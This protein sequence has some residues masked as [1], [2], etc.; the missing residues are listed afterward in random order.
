MDDDL[1]VL[2]KIEHQLGKSDENIQIDS[3]DE[4]QNL[5]LELVS[6]ASKTVDIFTRDLAVR[7]YD[8]A[9]FITALRDLVVR[10]D[11]T[12]IRI[13]IIDPDKPIKHG[14]RI[15]ELARRLSSSIEIRHVHIDNRSDPQSFLIA[16]GRGIL[17]RKLAS[18]FEATVNFNNPL[19]CR[20][21]LTH[22]DEVWGRSQP[23]LDFK[24]LHI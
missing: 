9:K 12:Q 10:N 5:S 22:F 23:V 17:H 1:E 18:R 19:F 16:D 21:C 7:I 14:H 6:Q 15:I 3:S 8:D 13:L 4:N 2:E 11:K 20:E 24:R